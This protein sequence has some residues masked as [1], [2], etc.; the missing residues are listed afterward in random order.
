MDDKKALRVSQ[1]ERA[2]ELFATNPDIEAKRVAELLDVT[3]QIVYEYRRDPNFHQQV[4]DRF[5]VEL[6]NEV[7]SM[8]SALKREVLAGNVQATR[9]MFEYMNK[10]QKNINITIDSPFENWLKKQGVEEAEVVQEELPVMAEFEELPPRTDKNNH[11]VI[12]RERVKIKNAP[13]KD[14]SVKSRNKARRELYKWQKRAK[15]AGVGS[16]PSRRPTPGQRKAWEDSIIL[17]E[18]QASELLQEQAGNNKTPC[19]PKS[20]KQASPKPSTRPKT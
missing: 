12:H 6:E 10:L 9:L 2:V 14:K 4:Q 7:P 19:K 11:M 5:M 17:K 15:L 20:Q 13:L 18:K 8:V 3:P 1:R 16:L